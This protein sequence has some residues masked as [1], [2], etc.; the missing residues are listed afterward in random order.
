MN[1][2]LSQ[3]HYCYKIHTS[4][5][6]STAYPPSID[7]PPIEITSQFLQKNLAHTMFFIDDVHHST[8]CRSY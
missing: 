2:L 5:T 1:D 3:E 7:N 8:N 4:L 6:K